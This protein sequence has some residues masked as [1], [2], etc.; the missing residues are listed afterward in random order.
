MISVK[1]VR[2]FSLSFDHYAKFMERLASRQL[3]VLK[4]ASAE[5]IEHAQFELE[6][7]MSRFEHLMERRPLLLNS[8]LL[9]QNPHNV[10]EWINRIQLYEGEQ[11][12]QT[13]TFEEAVRKCNRR[14]D[15]DDGFSCA[16]P[17]AGTIDAKSQS[18][19]LAELWIF[20]SKLVEATG[21]KD[22]TRTIFE[23]ATRVAFSKVDELARVWC[24]YVQFQLRHG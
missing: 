19:S 7:V 10:H 9:R 14:G 22:A 17:F 18:G 1:T 4:K 11:E 23:R 2:D 12:M 6:L 8:V 20:M 5:S 3:D 15:N 21:N 13:E 16:S 24:E